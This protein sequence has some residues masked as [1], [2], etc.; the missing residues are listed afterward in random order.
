MNKPIEAGCLAIIIS[1]FRNPQ[2]IGSVVKVVEKVGNLNIHRGR[3]CLFRDHYAW[4]CECAGEGVYVSEKHLLRIDDYD[5][6][7]DE[8]LANIDQ[9]VEA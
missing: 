4:F 3:E 1:T 9:E 6:S 5:A 7:A 8:D 2:Y